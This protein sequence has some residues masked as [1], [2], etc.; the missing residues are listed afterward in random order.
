MIISSQHYTDEKI[1]ASYIERI[2]AGETFTAC[3]ATLKN[4]E[5]LAWFDITAVL[6]DGH[7]RVEAY[8]R[9]GLKIEFVEDDYNYQAELDRLGLDKFLDTNWYDGDWYDIETGKIIF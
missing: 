2:Q 1:V 6:I 3:I 7:H 8:K 9:L 5:E 4:N